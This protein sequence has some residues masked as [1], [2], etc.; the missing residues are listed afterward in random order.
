MY[1]EVFTLEKFKVFVTTS[2]DWPK[3]GGKQDTGEEAHWP[4]YI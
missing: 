4:S 3:Y 2:E 1:I